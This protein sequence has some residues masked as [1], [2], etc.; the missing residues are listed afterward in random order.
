MPRSAAPGFPSVTHSCITRAGIGFLAAAVLF[1][2]QDQSARAV[3]PIVI[4]PTT[5]FS[6]GNATN[7]GLFGSIY[8]FDAIAGTYSVGNILDPANGFNTVQVG[9][10]T[11]NTAAGIH[12]GTADTL[13]LT[14][15][16]GADGAT[17]V[18]TAP[19]ITSVFDAGTN[20]GT[21]LNLT[22]YVRV[23]PAMVNVPL[24]F[25]LGLDD[26]GKL[27]I[28]GTTVINNGGIHGAT[29]ITQQ[30]I[31]TVAGLY[32]ISIG[33]YDGHASQG[34]LTADFAGAQFVFP[35]NGAPL[36]PIVL[37]PNAQ[38]TQNYLTTV[39]GQVPPDPTL[40]QAVTALGNLALNGATGPEYSAAVKELS[41]LKYAALE[42]QA[43]GAIDFLT[44]DLDDY[45]AH[46]RTD[47]GD[48][49]PGNGVDLGGLHVASGGYDPALQNIASHLL[50]YNGNRDG[51]TL[52]DSPKSLLTPTEE[53]AQPWNFFTRGIVV[54]SQHLSSPN[55]PHADTVNGTLQF[56]ADYQIT[57]HFLAGAYFCYAHSDGSLD[58]EGSNASAD[59][60][61][62]GIFGSYAEDGWYANALAAGGVSEFDAERAIVLPG[63]SATAKSK[64]QGEEEYVYLS[65]GHDFHSGNWTFGP[66]AGLQYVHSEL[67]SFSES[68]A[69]GLDLTVNSHADNSLRSRLGGRVYYAAQAGG[70]VWRPF[71][72]AAWQ[73]EFFESNNSLTSQFT[74][75]GVGT[76]TVA[77]ESNSRDSALI[78]AGTDIDIDAD[79]TVFTAYRV[80]AG[81]SNFFAQSVEAGVK[82]NF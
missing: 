27:V 46:R 75:A 24:T 43:T 71:L 9:S 44:N 41:P 67:D 10:Y 66:M 64:P 70:I 19:H 28:N 11:V 29:V 2:A 81:A 78:S 37:D 42:E 76:F 38:T 45:L 55:V 77:T 17:V 26:G 49:R 18:Y 13:P 62:P 40:G 30:A 5:N 7:T 72:D 53:P 20:Q 34:V 14:T 61:I 60:Y 68:N 32:P 8:N 79:T 54:L 1:L 48:F 36:Q 33:Y 12:Y 74:G 3:P 47:A 6:L 65:G 63:F 56:G 21:L 31:F 25:S 22:G 50:A 57:P 15:W 4:T 16:L 23:T 80:E 51:R 69:G 52:S 35:N 39:L 82:I 58:N 73:H 59:S